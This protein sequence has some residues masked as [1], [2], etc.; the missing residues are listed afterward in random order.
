MSAH[1]LA[2]LLTRCREAAEVHK[3]AEAQE[4]LRR[5]TD[6]LATDMR[7]INEAFRRFD[8]DSSGHL[9]AEETEH[10]CAYLGWTLEKNDFMDLDRECRLSKKIWKI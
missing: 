8:I 6:G 10:M 2:Y 5:I 3:F 1:P 4:H 7:Q 9:D